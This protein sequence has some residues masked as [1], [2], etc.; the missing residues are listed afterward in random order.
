MCPSSSW[1]A[2]SRMSR[3]LSP[4]PHCKPNR[5]QPVAGAATLPKT[6]L[7]APRSSCLSRPGLH[8][9]HC[10]P[11]E[12]AGSCWNGPLSLQPTASCSCT[13]AGARGFTTWRR[14]PWTQPC[15]ASPRRCG[16]T[17]RASRACR[18]RSAKTSSC[19]AAMPT[20]PCHTKR[21]TLP[22]VPPVRACS[23]ACCTHG[24]HPSQC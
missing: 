14:A 2:A 24:V 12:H 15:P 6:V 10:K 1:P 18:R 16:W 17:G 21:V 5:C 8:R 3:S 9:R 19:P 13:S 4:H 20:L 22:S 11:N 23:A 7:V